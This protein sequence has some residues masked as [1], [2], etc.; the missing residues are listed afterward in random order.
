MAHKSI[1][2][3]EDDEDARE[4]LVFFLENEG[5]HVL[6]ASHGEEALHHLRNTEVCAILL[7]LMMPVMNGWTFRSE[8][9]K[10]PRI[11][12]IPVAVITAD[13]NAT[14][15]AAALGVQELMVKPVDLRRLLAFVDRHCRGASAS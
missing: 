5:Y 7:D 6:E 3:V 14:Q 1:L 9:L 4:A 8:Q 13:E 11:A 10:D 12:S 2:I 15:S